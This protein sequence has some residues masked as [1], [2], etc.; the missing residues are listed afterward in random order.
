[1]RKRIIIW[2]S[3]L[4]MLVLAWFAIRKSMQNN[5]LNEEESAFAV[6]DTNG[7][8][9]I[10]IAT[11]TNKKWLLERKS[12]GYWKLNNTWW[13]AP[14]VMETLMQVIHDVEVKRPVSKLEHNSVVKSIATK[15]QKVEIYLRGQLLK[16]YF[17]GAETDNYQGSYFLMKDAENPFV[18]NIPGFNGYL[19]IRYDVN[20]NSWRDPHI[21][22]SGERTLQEVKV[23]YPS[24][25]A[26]NFTLT[27]HDSVVKVNGKGHLDPEHVNLFIYKTRDLAV[28]L[29]YEK[30]TQAH[31][32][33]VS[34][35]TPIAIISTTDKNPELSNTIK[36]YK[37][38]QNPELYN[39]L[40][41]KKNELV[42]VQ[43]VRT[44]FLLVNA[45]YLFR[46]VRR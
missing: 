26:D 46:P 45:E 43:K 34:K 31:V 24:K 38:T 40:L 35:L 11:K 25:P 22:M 5:T 44:D 30:V 1:M 6:A 8:D 33:S 37:N 16:T 9:K 14:T 20:P 3:V 41:G 28:N 27:I 29:F 23:E 32:D 10:F 39:A 21:F 13:V 36:I 18:C 4:A 12:G 7:I 17:V 42:N 2:L 15:H 19:T